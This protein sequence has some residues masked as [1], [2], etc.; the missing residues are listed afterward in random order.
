MTHITIPLPDDLVSFLDDMV[1]ANKA[2]SRAGLVRRVLV[3]WR[4]EAI[5][6]AVRE[7]KEEYAHG[8][9]LEGDLRALV[10]RV[11]SSGL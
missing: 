1:A 8:K 4:E 5:L 6:D 9:Y 10:K 7:A 3:Q 2:E 11:R